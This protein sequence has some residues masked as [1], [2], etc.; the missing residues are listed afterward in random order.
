MGLS[1]FLL[2]FPLFLLYWV[3]GGA[4]LAS[5]SYIRH[6]N[7]HK[8]RFGC[9]FTLSALMSAIGATYTGY[10]LGQKQI[11]FCMVHAKTLVDRL[12]AVFG[13]GGFAFG[14]MAISWF[15]LLGGMG[16][17]VLFIS[18]SW[19]QSWMDD[20]PERDGKLEYNFKKV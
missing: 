1:L 9:L 2:A 16:M 18:R 3:V 5:I 4:V 15:F 20:D 10:L 17:F 7:I 19:N 13:C 11:D 12:T 6:M 14:L 8:A